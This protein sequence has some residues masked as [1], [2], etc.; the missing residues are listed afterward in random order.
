MNE[1]VSVWLCANSRLAL[2]GRRRGFDAVEHLAME[3]DAGAAGPP[4]DDRGGVRGAAQERYRRA[5]ESAEKEKGGGG[6]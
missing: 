3:A 6:K 1:V 5:G 2:R 4:E